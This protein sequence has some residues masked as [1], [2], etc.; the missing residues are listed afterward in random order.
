MP[1]S[2]WRYQEQREPGR[3]Y[4]D[5]RAMA[6]ADFDRRPFLVNIVSKALII[7]ALFSGFLAVEAAASPN[8]ADVTG[9][10]R[11][12]PSPME[13]PLRLAQSEDVEIYIDEYGRRVI[14]DSFTGEVLGIQRP[15]Q[16]RDYRHERRLREL[17]RDQGGFVLGD[18]DADIPYKPRPYY[19]GRPV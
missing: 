12:A 2:C 14:V 19:Q 7:T 16:N 5:W 8:P 9:I 15:R 6:P 3:D 10:S 1:G 4:S 13:M 18:P 11:T 17:N